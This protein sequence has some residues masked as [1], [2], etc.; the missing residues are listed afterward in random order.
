MLEYLFIGAT[1]D[2]RERGW[3]Q[4]LGENPLLF[5]HPEFGTFEF[6]NACYIQRNADKVRRRLWWSAR[7]RPAI[8][9]LTVGGLLL[10]AVYNL[11]T[12][13]L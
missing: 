11:A 6:F 2:L 5:S 13:I 3:T 10:V 8:Y 12:R 4:S 1:R 9:I 7:I